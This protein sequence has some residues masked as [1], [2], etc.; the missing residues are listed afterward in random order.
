[1]PGMCIGLSR[2]GSIYPGVGRRALPVEG[3][4]HRADLVSRPLAA[5]FLGAAHDAD[6]EP[7]RRR[8][9]QRKAGLKIGDEALF[10]GTLRLWRKVLLSRKILRPT[11]R[12][13]ASAKKIKSNLSIECGSVEVVGAGQGRAHPDRGLIS[14]QPFADPQQPSDI[15]I[16]HYVAG[17]HP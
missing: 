6:I 13:C 1:M 9:Y 2:S 4:G 15:S 5:K 8:P 14:P 7:E 11:T 10:L 17:R 12:P 16:R 3:N